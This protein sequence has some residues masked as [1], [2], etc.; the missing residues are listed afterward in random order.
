MSEDTNIEIYRQ[1]YETFRHLDKLRWQM[2]QIVVA[3]GSLSALVVRATDDPIE[4]WFYIAIGAIL[5]LIALAIFRIDCGIRHNGRV[6]KEFGAK[7]GDEA[8]PDNAKNWRSTSVYMALIVGLAGSINV[9]IGFFYYLKAI[10]G[11]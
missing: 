11:D 2:L 7:L 10:C 9:G 3:V 5:N 1:R 6:L 8:I 4:P